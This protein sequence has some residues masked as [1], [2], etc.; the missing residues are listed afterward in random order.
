MYIFTLDNQVQDLF[1]NGTQAGSMCMNDTIMQYAGKIWTR[2]ILSGFGFL[3]FLL[4][5]KI[6]V[7]QITVG[8]SDLPLFKDSEFLNVTFSVNF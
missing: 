8:V 3:L 4:P 5:L 7:R 2:K 1:I 6:L